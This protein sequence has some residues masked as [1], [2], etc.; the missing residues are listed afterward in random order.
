MPKNQDSAKLGAD[1]RELAAAGST[2]DCSV[3]R[4]LLK[5]T[6]KSKF[7]WS[8]AFMSRGCL[9]YQMGEQVTFGSGNC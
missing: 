6:Q 7:T 2:V 3:A 8:G 1:L 4:K 9:N 5:K